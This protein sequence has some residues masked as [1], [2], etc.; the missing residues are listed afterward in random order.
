MFMQAFFQNRLVLAFIILVGGIAFSDIIPPDCHYVAKRTF[1]SKRDVSE[2]IVV[3]GQREFPHKRWVVTPDTPVVLGK[4]PYL[5]QYET[6]TLYAVDSTHFYSIPLDSINLTE[7]WPINRY[8]YWSDNGNLYEYWEPDSATHWLKIIDNYAE[9][10]PLDQTSSKDYFPAFGWAITRKISYDSLGNVM[11]DTNYT[12]HSQIDV[13]LQKSS[14]STGLTLSSL[15][16][17]V[18]FVSAKAQ[19][20]TI[21]I[22]NV[23]GQT[24][25]RVQKQCM[26]MYP[27]VISLSH[28]PAGVYIAE[29]RG[30]T[31]RVTGKICLMR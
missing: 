16:D 23:R 13:S 15:N 31:Q 21:S 9:I 28:L 3:V 18:R 25:M 26:P 7:C 6:F 14:L 8:N 24:M 1:F 10:F 30:E 12:P 29:V 20:V 4:Q 5:S 11:S 17:D 2:A 22:V 27:N 19:N